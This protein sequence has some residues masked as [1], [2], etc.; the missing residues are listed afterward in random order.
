MVDADK[1]I[2]NL[3]TEKGK[4]LNDEQRKVIEGFTSLM[5]MLWSNQENKKEDNE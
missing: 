1:T 3:E 5:N 2:K 4:Q